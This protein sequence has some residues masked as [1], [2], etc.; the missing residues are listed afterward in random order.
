MDMTVIR[1]KKWHLALEPKEGEITELELQLWRVF[2]GFTRW[3]EECEKSAN[4][5]VLTAHELSVLHI[6]RMNDRPKSGID[7]GKL[8]N[9]DDGFNIAYTIKKLVKL[10]LIKKSPNRTKNSKA[11]QYEITEA[12]IKNTNTYREVRLKLLISKFHNDE[13]NFNTIAKAI[14]PLKTIY[15]DAE[16]AAAFYNPNSETKP[17]KHTKHKK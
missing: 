14:S 6:I 13:T 16:Q 17:K 2:N 4:G 7:I 12:G 8:L 5:S 10:G 11:T 3:V 9:R 15:E 1:E